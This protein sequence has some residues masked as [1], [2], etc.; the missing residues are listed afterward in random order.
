MD[1]RPRST[2]TS[3]G[4]GWSPS[5]PA[6]HCLH[7]WD[8]HI[9]ASKNRDLG[10]L[11]W[12]TSGQLIASQ[13]PGLGVGVPQTVTTFPPPTALRLGSA[14]HFKLK[15]PLSFFR[16]IDFCVHNLKIFVTDPVTRSIRLV[17]GPYRVT[18]ERS[19]QTRNGRAACTP[20]LTGAPS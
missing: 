6:H 16:S 20:R 19:W 10:R 11:D 2:C 17:R 15:R 8:L 7:D 4:R 14:R 1:D 13:A 18:V 12:G 3:Q 5:E 9:T